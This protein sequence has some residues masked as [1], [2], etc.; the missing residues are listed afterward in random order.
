[1]LPQAEATERGP[2]RHD[3]RDH[4][5]HLG[6]TADQPRLTDDGLTGAPTAPARQAV[7][8]LGLIVAGQTTDHPVLTDN[9]LPSAPS[10]GD[11]PSDSTNRL[12]LP[13]PRSSTPLNSTHT[14]VFLQIRDK[15]L[16]RP[17][18]PTRTKPKGHD[19]R[20]YYC[21]YREYGHNTEE[22]HDLKNQIE[23]LIRQGH[24]RWY[25]Q[26]Q[27]MPPNENRHRE[28]RSSPRPKGPIKKQIDVIIGG[29]DLGGNSS[30]ARKAYA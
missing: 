14:E 22:C 4:V 21:F 27:H 29:P 9:D 5:D 20:R 23:D 15:G 26:D 16:L 1:V 6:L 2:S 18:N 8:Q 17:P 11:R 19:K 28:G 10:E 3:S 12:E 7:N 24:L 13:S 30:S 25:V